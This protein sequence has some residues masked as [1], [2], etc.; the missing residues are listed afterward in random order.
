MLKC[1]RYPHMV[2]H[3]GQQPR[4]VMLVWFCHPC[5]TG[6]EHNQTCPTG[7]ARGGKSPSA[8]HLDR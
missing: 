6:S 4:Y 2:S 5:D 7:L 1:G 8:R 3:W